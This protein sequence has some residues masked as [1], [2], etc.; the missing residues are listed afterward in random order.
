M[1][2]HGLPVFPDPSGHIV[3]HSGG[4]GVLIAGTGL[5]QG[6]LQAELDSPQGQAAWKACVAII[7]SKGS[8]S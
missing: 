1:R 2:V 4:I 6:Q 8:G 5:S 7:T 3:V